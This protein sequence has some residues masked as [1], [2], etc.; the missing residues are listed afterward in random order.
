M[1]DLELVVAVYDDWGIGKD[2][3]QPL[4][5]PEDRK[6][7]RELTSGGAVIVGRK[8]LADFPGGR[9]LPNRTNIILTRQ[10]IDIENAI[11]AHS[12]G[13]AL[14]AAE[15]RGR[16][17]VIGGSSV[18]EALLSHCRTAHVTKVHA[19]PESD[20]F[21]PDL[22]ASP[23]WQLRAASGLLEQDGLRYEFTEYGRVD[24]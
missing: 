3:T 23:D 10:D 14:D 19:T 12:A 21:F 11:V 6:H 18:Y 20:V 4:V 5:V 1:V 2:G 8:T 16:V 17:F 15:G 9:P 22:D 7:F 13:Q 24:A